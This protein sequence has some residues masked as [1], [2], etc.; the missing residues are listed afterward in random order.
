MSEVKLELHFGA[1]APP[2]SQQIK[3]QINYTDDRILK[4]D[5][6]AKALVRVYLDGLITDGENEKARKRLMKKITN[7]LNLF[8]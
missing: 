7:Y 4:F 1:L 2:V 6:E 5:E 8:E 3:K